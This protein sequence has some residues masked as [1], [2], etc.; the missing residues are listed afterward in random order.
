MNSYISQNYIDDIH[1]YLGPVLAFSVVLLLISY[2]YF[3]NSS[4]LNAMT[5][6]FDNK[7]IAQLA[8][9]LSDLENKYIAL[10]SG[11]N[12]DMARYL[13]FSDDFNRVHFSSESTNVAGNLSLLGNEI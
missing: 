3:L 1:R 8:L 12:I 4:V 6:E 2:V 5:R 13:G 10:K 7:Q 11:I 9:N